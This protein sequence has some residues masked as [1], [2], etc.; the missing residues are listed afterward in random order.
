[1]DHRFL[2]SLRGFLGESPRHHGYLGTPAVGCKPTR[3]DPK[4][5]GQGWDWP[6]PFLLLLLPTLKSQRRKRNDSASCFYPSEPPSAHHP[7][8]STSY[9]HAKSQILLCRQDCSSAFSDIAV[10]GICLW[11]RTEERQAAAAQGRATSQEWG[12]SDQ[13]RCHSRNPKGQAVQGW[14]RRCRHCQVLYAVLLNGETSLGVVQQGV[15]ETV[16]RSLQ[17]HARHFICRC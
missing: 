13:A 5:A 12:V 17:S 8:Q 3:P 6:D 15:V 14:W 7:Q 1:M 4:E 11:C 9:G 16:A 2:E 10:K